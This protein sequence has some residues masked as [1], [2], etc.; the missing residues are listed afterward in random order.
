MNI[1]EPQGLILLAV[2]Q[3]LSVTGEV[4]ND[5]LVSKH[6][7]DK[8]VSLVLDSFLNVPYKFLPPLQVLSD[9]TLSVVAHYITKW[10]TKATKRD[11]HC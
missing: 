3:S 2:L 5:I 6:L 11:S 10:H 7:K 1:T 9:I 4:I 8:I